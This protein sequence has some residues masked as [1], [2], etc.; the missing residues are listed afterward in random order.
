MPYPYKKFSQNP[1]T[2]LR[3][4][5]RTDRQTDRTENITSFLSGGNE[6]KF[7]LPDKLECKFEYKCH[8]NDLKPEVSAG[9][10]VP[11]IQSEWSEL[12][13]RVTLTVFV[14]N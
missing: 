8:F 12:K 6:C 1:F 7:Q 3:V 13:T 14:S 10:I 9:C 2:S 11:S 4:I 5:R